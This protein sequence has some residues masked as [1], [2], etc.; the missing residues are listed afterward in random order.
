VIDVVDHPNRYAARRRVLDRPADDR[1]GLGR[2]VEVVLSQVDRV[3]GPAEE[4]LDLACDLVC[5]L[6][7]VR[8]RP[9]V[10]KLGA[11]RTLTTPPNWRQRPAWKRSI[12][13]FSTG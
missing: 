3:L 5:L 2:E 4:G 7:T 1:G 6:A 12:L 13:V 8:E 11:Q 9:D 10:E